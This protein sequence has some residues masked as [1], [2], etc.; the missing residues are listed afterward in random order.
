MAL[1]DLLLHPAYFPELIVG[2]NLILRLA[3]EGR[4]LT[5]LWNYLAGRVDEDSRDGGALW[6]M[7]QILLAR[8]HTSDGLRIQADA[9]RCRRDFRVVHGDGSGPVVLAFIAPGDLSANLAVDLLLHGSNCTLWLRCVGDDDALSNLPLH[10]V[11]VIAAGPKVAEQDNFQRLAAGLSAAG[12]PLINGKADAIAGLRPERLALALASEDGVVVAPMA[13]HVGN[14]RQR[15]AC[16]DNQLFSLEPDGDGF[17]AKHRTALAAIVRRVGL[18]CFDLECAETRDG[19]L[20]ILSADVG[21]LPVVLGRA[22]KAL[23]LLCDAFTTRVS[24]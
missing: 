7:A 2:P 3:A 23:Q 22:P 14:T 21:G 9:L 16:I 15:I 4:S 10:D 19:R 6:D 5:P 17:I 11:A 18:D 24:R 8:G 1:D 13:G 12:W 20:A